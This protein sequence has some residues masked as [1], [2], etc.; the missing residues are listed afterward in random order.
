MTELKTVYSLEEALILY[1]LISMQH[2][3]ESAMMAENRK[4]G[5]DP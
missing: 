1:D 5:G 4:K 3:I 2:D